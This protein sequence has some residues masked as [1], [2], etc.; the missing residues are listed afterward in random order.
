M[1]FI[2]SPCK[3]QSNIWI[4]KWINS[5]YKKCVCMKAVLQENC[6]CEKAVWGC[7][8]G[9]R[10][11]CIVCLFWNWQAEVCQVIIYVLFV[12]ACSWYCLFQHAWHIRLQYFQITAHCVRQSKE[13]R[14]EEREGNRVRVDLG[15]VSEV[16]RPFGIFPWHQTGGNELFLQQRH[17][18]YWPGTPTQTQRPWEQAE[19]FSAETNSWVYG[20]HNL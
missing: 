6:A 13:R 8:G 16:E 9:K 5:V 18:G 14:I 1:C 2:H 20:Q 11:E 12:Y 17:Q 4:N 3:K 19:K 15:N 10:G 7:L